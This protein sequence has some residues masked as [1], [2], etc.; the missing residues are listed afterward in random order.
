MNARSTIS[1]PRSAQRD[2]TV[3]QKERGTVR[4]QTATGHN[5]IPPLTI[6]KVSLSGGKPG[7][8]TVFDKCEQN[9]SA[10]KLAS[11]R[12]RTDWGGPQTCHMNTGATHQ[13]LTN[14]LFVSYV[15]V[16]MF[17]YL[18]DII[19]FSDLVEE[20]MKCVKITFNIL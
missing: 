18:N 17:V 4:W 1:D 14:C 12:L 15:G 7:L 6:P 20:H 13:M 8:R 2:F 5:M 10:Y 9:Q 3:A 19:T 11:P 16:F